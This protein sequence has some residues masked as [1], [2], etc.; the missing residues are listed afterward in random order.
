ML[1][2]SF[3]KKM[4]AMSLHFFVTPQVSLSDGSINGLEEIMVVFSGC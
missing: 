3:I 4:E 2:V 1:C